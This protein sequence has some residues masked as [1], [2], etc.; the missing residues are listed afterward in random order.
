MIYKILGRT[1]LKVSAVGFGAIKLPKI[2]VDEAVELVNRAVDLG[3][4]FIDTARAYEDSEAKIGLALK[5]R[6]DEVYIA[7]KSLSRDRNGLLKDLNK[8]LKELR[9]DYIDIYKLHAVNDEKTYNEVTSSDGAI[10]GL[11]YA[12]KKGLI[13][14]T[15]ISMHFDLR[16]MRRAIESGYFDV[17]TVAYSPLDHESVDRAGIL[18][19]AKE[20]NV[21]TIIMKPLLGGQLVLPET[22]LGKRVDDPIARLS[23]RYILSNPNVDVVIPGIREMH[24][25]EENVRAVDEPLPM[26]EEERRELFNLIATIRVERYSHSET[27]QNC[28]RCGYCMRVCPQNVPTPEIFNAYDIYMNYP[29]EHRYQGIELYKSLRVKPDACIECGNCLEV[30]PMRLDIPNKIREIAK[31][32]EEL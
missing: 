5:D 32:F 21:G 6:R 25:I 31:V 2:S 10:K 22:A 29:K 17:I 3:V 20:Y 13:G 26:S 9:T 24:E 23:L 12:K 15:G 19:L 11:I 30:C 18:K 4:N 28:L 7:S 1:G 16:V 27:E 8:S 14:Y